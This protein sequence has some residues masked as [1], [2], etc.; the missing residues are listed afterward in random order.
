MYDIYIKNYLNPDGTAVNIEQLLYS[1]PIT[2]A[3]NALIDPVVKTEMGKA[4]T[5]EFGIW[6]K[7]LYFNGFLQLKTLFRI[8]YEGDTI[9]RG[10][11]LT[12]DSSP[13]SG[14]KKIHCEGDLA[15]FLDTYQE[16]TKEENRQETDILTYLNILID[17]HNAQVVESGEFDKMFTL[18]EVPGQYSEAI[19]DSQ[20]VVCENRKFGSDSWGQTMSAL[21]A[22]QKEFGG[23]FRTRYADG[24]AYLDWLNNWFKDETN[25]QKIAVG[26]NM[27]DL[28][29]SMEV[30]NVF[31]AVIP[32]GS[33]NGKEIFIDGYRTDIHGENNKRVLVPMVAQFYPDEKLNNAYHRKEDY[34]KAVERYGI[35]YKIQKFDNADTQEKLWNYCMQWILDNYAG[36]IT[37]FDVGALD[38]HH[39]SPGKE[40]F[41]T[42]DRV[43]L[44]YPNWNTIE[45]RRETV[46]SKMTMT[47]AT[48]NLHD[49]DKNKYNIG[50][51]NNILQ[52]KYGSSNSKGGGGGGASG[53]QDIEDDAYKAGFRSDMEGLQ[54]KAWLY[55]IDAKTDNEEYQKILAEDE[56]LAVAI[57][58]STYQVVY[59]YMRD[60]SGTPGKVV[61][62]LAMHG[63]KIEFSQDVTNCRVYNPDFDPTKINMINSLIL[64]VY[65]GNIELQEM[66]SPQKI[67][68]DFPNV[69]KRTIFE[70]QN[71]IENQSV[72]LKMYKK[73]H[74][75][76]SEEPVV[77]IAQDGGNGLLGAIKAGVGNSGMPEGMTM[78]M[79]GAENALKGVT[80]GDAGNFDTANLSTLIDVA[81]GKME[82][83][84]D[85]SQS[86]PEVQLN[87]QKQIEDADGNVV[88]QP[89]MIIGKD[90]GI[91][92]ASGTGENTESLR[93][94]L[95]V[96]DRI[97]ASKAEIVDLEALRARIQ[98]LEADYIKTHDLETEIAKI[99]Q[100]I[101]INVAKI[102]TARIT[103]I[104]VAGREAVWT[105]MPVMNSATFRAPNLGTTNRVTLRTEDGQIVTGMLVT[106]WQAGSFTPVSVYLSCLGRFEQQQ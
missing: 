73:N 39:V 89:G 30:D 14:E 25:T 23:Y 1:I 55:I 16:G 21:E 70:L 41:L 47:Q 35:I 8:V 92:D 28:S 82:L 52:R 49:P 44:S 95:I 36:S 69:P 61:K 15:F 56:N 84:S 9:F 37:S 83:N 87:V 50:I 101:S 76:E 91:Y 20:K 88:W 90:F 31:T 12:I 86:T 94:R 19:T 80:S 79:D 40:K 98:T 64:D 75:K 100:E 103:S 99:T 57:L 42:G 72:F 63:G 43:E 2:N 46:T 22:V 81:N 106:D 77:S 33:A 11:V 102:T 27:I 29:D 85:T 13:M 66:Y 51:P 10:R 62:M 74:P 3:L 6:P 58:K 38:L 18:G 32:I 17:N 78:L 59:D 34:V 104:S 48:Y 93:Q 67:A 24:V 5:F 68:E 4:G 97:I 26:E 7:H 96:T 54:Q 105:T 45:R 53:A 71:S 65:N 60:P